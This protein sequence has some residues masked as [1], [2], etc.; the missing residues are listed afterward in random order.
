MA[1][2]LSP[3]RIRF[4]LNRLRGKLWVK[5]L[6]VCRLSI[7]GAFM[8]K[9]ADGTGLAEV[10]PEIDAESIK[11]LLTIMASSMLVIAT[12]SVSSM[13]SAYA[14]ASNTATPRA[15]SLVV[16]D[17][18]SQNALSTFLGAFI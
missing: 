16:A 17:D 2:I 4:L 9:L 8:A 13:V 6:A 18:A 15:F 14:S 3:D 12:F 11:P 5:P 1:S 7:A 10:V